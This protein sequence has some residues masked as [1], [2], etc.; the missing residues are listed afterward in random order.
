MQRHLERATK[1]VG[2]DGRATDVAGAI[3]RPDGGAGLALGDALQLAR[4]GG[5]WRQVAANVE[6]PSRR[7]GLNRNI[8]RQA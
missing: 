5:D 4:R 6:V 2:T 7:G 1:L 8:V 3:H